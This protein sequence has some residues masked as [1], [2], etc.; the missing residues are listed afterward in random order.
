MATA[1]QYRR[2]LAPKI[3]DRHAWIP[4]DT[5]DGQY[6][7]EALHIIR[8]WTKLNHE[9]IHNAIVNELGSEINLRFWNEHNF[10]FRRGNSFY[11]AKGATPLLDEFVHD[12]TLGLRLIPLNMSQP[13]LVV[14]GIESDGNLGFAP[15]GA[16]RNMS[17][18]DH[19]RLNA[20]KTEEQL[21]DEETQ[22]LDIRFYSGNIDISELP[23]AYKNA[24]SIIQQ[25]D[26]FDLGTVVDKILPY[27]SI[28]AG[29]WEKD[30]PWKQRRKKR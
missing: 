3:H 9:V 11:H 10:V 15:H 16:G 26:R 1:K 19:K 25:M 12:S 4:A 8:K 6:Y 22:D 18:T 17:R 14:R 24:E 13:I 23:S 29:D 5:A 7:W 2:K 28:M 20:F 30:M 27:G 21:F